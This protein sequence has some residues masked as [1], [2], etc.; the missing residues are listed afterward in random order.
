M[1]VR[2]R[3]LGVQA[4][5]VRWSAQ[6]EEGEW[7]RVFICFFVCMFVSFV[8]HFVEHQYHKSAFAA[9][10]T[11]KKT[12]TRTVQI[13]NNKK[14]ALKLNKILHVPYEKFQTE[15]LSEDR[16]GLNRLALGLHRLLTNRK[17][18][19]VTCRPAEKRFVCVCMRL[20]LHTLYNG[21][22]QTQFT[23]TSKTCELV[24]GRRWVN[25]PLFHRKWCDVVTQ[26]AASACR[27]VTFCLA[28]PTG[29]VSSSQTN[30]PDSHGCLRLCWFGGGFYSFI[31][32]FCPFFS[33]W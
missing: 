3:G 16:G 2:Y 15:S 31:L 11:N 22:R 5:V 19:A 18:R 6:S 25:G 21:V 30:C 4:T 28:R 10:F 29:G 1:S 32:F 14:N 27:H 26:S 13:N 24:S 12:S 17:P 8:S 33:S 23:P 7:K 9:W 20:L